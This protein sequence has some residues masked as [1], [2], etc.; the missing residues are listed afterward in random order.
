MTS[1]EALRLI[2]PFLKNY[3][4]VLATGFISRT[5]QNV[6]HRP[7]NF[8]VIGSMGMVSSIALGIALSKPKTRVIGLDG[9]GAVLMNLGTLPMVGALKPKNF[10]HIVLDNGSYESTGG[11]KSL[12]QVV[13]LEK[14]AKSSGYRVTKTVKNESALKSALRSV[15]KNQGPAFLLVKVNNNSGPAAP[16][17][18]DSPEK[19]TENLIHALR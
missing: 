7:E 4:A 15:F 6:C 2:T 5:A 14:I 17:I 19:I 3:P 10:I 16:R 11:Q 1:K 18:T 9:D 12:S 8:Y 13:N